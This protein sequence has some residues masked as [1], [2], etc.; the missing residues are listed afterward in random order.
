MRLNGVDL[1]PVTS[2]V[3]GQYLMKGAPKASTEK[4]RFIQECIRMR[5]EVNKRS[6]E[7]GQQW[8]K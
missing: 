1:G 4:K 7:D 3:I 5:N 8:K 6:L 2:R